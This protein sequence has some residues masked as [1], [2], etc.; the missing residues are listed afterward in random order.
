MLDDGDIVSDEQV[1]DSELVLQVL[2]QVDDLSL[3]RD[4]KSAHWFIADDET[5]LDRQGAGD[6]NSL[7]LSTAEFMRKS[8]GMQG[9]E[10]HVL[11]ELGNPLAP[12]S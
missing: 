8:A 6:A 1:G 9:V 2:E 12:F 4:V 7:S 5:G 11:K 10:T 3:D